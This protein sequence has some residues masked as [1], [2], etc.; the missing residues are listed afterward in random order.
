MSDRKKKR[1]ITLSA[2]ND[3][4]LKEHP[5]IN[6]SGWANSAL[7]GYRD[8]YDQTAQKASQTLHNG[9]VAQAKESK[10]R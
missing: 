5:E 8:F 4:W 2:A 10:R 1:S 9:L 6:F 7:D 3:K